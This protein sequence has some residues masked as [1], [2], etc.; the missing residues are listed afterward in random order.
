MSATL[1]HPPQNETRQMQNE[2]PEP[3]ADT[4]PDASVLEDKTP[5]W[6]R[7]PAVSAVYVVILGT[8]LLVFANR[9]LWHTD[10][11]DHVNY[12]ERIL[13][14]R[15]LPS[16]EP[17]LP[18][19]SGMPM[20]N[21][22]WLAQLGMAVLFERL[23]I[24]GIQFACGLVIVLSIGTVSWAATRRSGSVVFGLLGAAV[25]LWMNM[26]QFLAV[27]P[28]LTGL[29]LYCI[30]ISVLLSGGFRR[31]AAWILLPL[32]F[33]VWANCHGSFAVG[34][35]VMATTGVGHAISVLMRTR[36]I[37]AAL[38]SR[39]FVRLVL[40][41]Q[42]CAVAVLLN[43]WGLDLYDTV[44]KIGTHPNIRSM[45][46]WDPMTLRMKQGQAAAVMVCLLF[47]AVKLSPRHVRADEA[48]LLLVTGGMALWSSRMVNWW[49][50]VMAVSIAGHGAA[51]WRSLRHRPRPTEARVRTGLWTVVNAG[52]CWV[53]FALTTLGVQVVHG[54]AP[55]PHRALSRQTPLNAIEFLNAAETLPPGITFM[56]A[57]WA[58]AVMQ[59]G[60]HQLR[61]M[62][63]LH[64]HVIPEEIWTD[65]IRLLAGPS[66]W[67][68]LLDRYG[69][70]LVVAER[71]RNDRL[72][73]LATDSGDWETLYQDAQAVVLQRKQLIQ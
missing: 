24:A 13:R 33:A 60:P 8:L 41:T 66:D 34:L 73:R 38:R 30:L 18:L 12:G 56:P 3:Q 71:G 29:L 2:L 20:V 51:A 37:T 61:P 6:L 54:K 19:A 59:F 23:G 62:V 70:N 43:P 47:L 22:A 36:S 46:E 72:M 68:G 35:L 50:P 32:M 67:N 15:S 17:L 14:A 65:Y 52:L 55:D 49:A 40:L 53:F 7:T 63:N 31:R 26:Q 69:I 58:G 45:F 9:P 27:R 64:V 44:L 11:W 39:R 42:L 48:L 10:L 57:E 16:T 25:F 4:L 28:Q 1:E 21:T 5:A